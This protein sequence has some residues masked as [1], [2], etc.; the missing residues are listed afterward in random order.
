[1]PGN[2][3][4]LSPRGLGILPCLLLLGL[5]T[6]LDGGGDKQELEVEGDVGDGLFT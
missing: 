4:T 5:L 3:D 1:M 2:P 6:N